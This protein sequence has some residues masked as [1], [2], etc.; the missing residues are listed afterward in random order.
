[1]TITMKHLNPSVKR[2]ADLGTVLT[3]SIVKTLPTSNIST[4][5]KV[6]LAVLKLRNGI[7]P[8]L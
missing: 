6:H 5:D 7:L 1:M 2:S 8:V 4:N 3:G